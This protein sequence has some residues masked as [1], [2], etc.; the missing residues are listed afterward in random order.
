MVAEQEPRPRLI[1]VD[2]FHRMAEAGIFRP[3]ERVELLDGVVIGVPPPSPPHSDAT[4]R[5][6]ELFY[7]RFRERA[8][9]GIQRPVLLDDLSEPEPD[10]VLARRRDEGYRDR[11]PGPGDVLLVVEVALSSL[12]HDRGKK[13]RAY[14]RSGI[15]EVWIVDVARR[16][17]EVYAQPRD[18][19]YAVTRIANRGDAIAPT[20]FPADAIPVAS[21]VPPGPP[22]G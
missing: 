7:E 9:I 4:D 1:T 6:G 16:R 2:E 18:G 17:V 19:S 14:A 3:G 20:A 21:L 8:R 12:G 11:H 5:I 22:G 15:A 13:L 10:V